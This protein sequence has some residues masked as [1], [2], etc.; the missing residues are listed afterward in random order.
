MSKTTLDLSTLSDISDGT[1]TVKVKAKAN[2]YIDSEFSNEVN[3]TKAP[4]VYTFNISAEHLTGSLN[5]GSSFKYNEPP[6]N[7]SDNSGVLTNSGA[8]FGKYPDGKR[9][10]LESGD[11]ISVNVNKI[12]FWGYRIEV[13]GVRYDNVTL[14]SP[15]VV[16]NNANIKIYSVHKP[17]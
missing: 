11:S 12:Y 16:S 14:D 17:T 5:D 10:S 9:F 2:G 6:S 1:H 4:A 7:E 15:I 3:Y 8:W 13:D